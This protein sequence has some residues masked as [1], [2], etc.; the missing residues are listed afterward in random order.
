MEKYPCDD[1]PRKDTCDTWDA[2]YCCE[3]CSYN[4]LEDCENC[5]TWDI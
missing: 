2:R 5:D 3:L 4:G 1:C